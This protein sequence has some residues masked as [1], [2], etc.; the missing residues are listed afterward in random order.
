MGTTA[1]LPE[2]EPEPEAVADCWP[3]D[4]EQLS[5]ERRVIAR[6]A[7]LALTSVRWQDFL[8]IASCDH[9]IARKTWDFDA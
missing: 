6:D 7:I 2:P 9:A 5:E 1:S 4:W 8:T 3:P